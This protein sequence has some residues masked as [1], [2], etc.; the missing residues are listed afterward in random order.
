M[1]VFGVPYS[2]PEL[3][4]KPFGGSRAAGI[5]LHLANG[6]LFG[7]LYSLV[8]PRLPG[9]GPVKG[10]A[11]GMAEHLATWPVTRFLPGVQLWGN[12]RA[13]CQAVWRHLLFGAV[14]GALEAR[15]AQSVRARVL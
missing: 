4:A 12:H 5:P 6:A 7:A 15:L 9:R 14:L 11:A 13:F 10:M 2:D 1:R 3:L 8:A